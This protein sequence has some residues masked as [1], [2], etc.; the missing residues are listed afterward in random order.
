M[1]PILKDLK[2]DILKGCRYY[3]VKS[4]RFTPLYTVN[5][6]VYR[7]LE[8]GIKQCYAVLPG[9]C[10][11][12]VAHGL[13][14]GEVYP[15]LSDFDLSIVFDSSEP[16]TFYAKLR[17][18]WKVLQQ[19]LPARDL[20]VFT[21]HEFDLWQRFGG[22]WEP[23]DEL[24]HWQCLY[25]A[26][27]RHHHW[28]LSNPQAERDR[29]RYVLATYHR[30]LYAALK[31]E[32]HTPL[33]AITAR[34]NL[35]KAFCSSVLALE[36]QYLTMGNQLHRLTQWIADHAKENLAIQE[37]LQMR[38]YQF[39]RGV[40]SSLKLPVSTHAYHAIHT[41]LENFR[42]SPTP[43]SNGI[44]EGEKTF[45]LFNLGE[46]EQRITGLASSIVDM[47]KAYL[48]SLMLVSNGSPV[49]Y[50]LFVILKEDLTVEDVEEVLRTL[51][52]IFRIYDD[53]WFNE[54]F[55]AKVPIVYSE[56]MFLAHLQVWPFDKN[57]MHVHRR[58]L[59]GKD[60]YQEL[61]GDHT[62]LTAENNLMEEILRENITVSRSL[63]QIYVEQLKPALYDAVTLHFPRLYVVQKMGWAPTTVEEAVWYY[64]KIK[65]STA[66]NFPK[67][68]LERYGRQR[69]HALD[70]AIPEGAFEEVW[71]FLGSGLVE[72]SYDHVY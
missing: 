14:L 8:Q 67:V 61:L 17:N 55:P 33:L 47:L 68:F 54:H 24:Q 25:G 20:L 32:P 6:Q 31:E 65:D 15:G 18:P 10:S 23:L 72:E 26:D 69:M 58:I 11:I 48:S 51:H 3:L 49:G 5:C 36:R 52:V 37:L 1:F 71:A 66:V 35:Y 27:L 28:N 50:L 42:Y 9:V 29:L 13:A 16:Q 44:P 56:K 64:G 21:K 53:P 7:L 45:P 30:L 41:A 57:Y 39:H 70:H 34:R 59:Y 43:L 4:N 62:L 12:Y 63:H 2:K 38:K 46:V 60:I 22:G 40:I 19:L